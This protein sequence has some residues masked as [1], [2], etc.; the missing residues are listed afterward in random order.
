LEKYLTTIIIATISVSIIQIIAPESDG[1][2]KYTQAIGILIVLCVCLSPISN[3]IHSLNEGLF[4]DLKNELL[5]DSD[6]D[7]NNYKDIFNNYLKDFS[8]SEYIIEIKDILKQ[9]FDIPEKE[10]VINI[11]TNNYDNTIYVD[12]IQIMLIGNSVFKNPYAIEDYIYTLTGAKTHVSIK[13]QR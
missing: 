5:E 10:S 11:L 7:V 3:V 6:G 13:I 1:L 4:S 9:E 2:K 12:E 8:K